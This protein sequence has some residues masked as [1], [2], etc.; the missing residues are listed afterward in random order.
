MGFLEVG[1]P[2]TWAENE[3]LREQIKRDGLTQ[4]LHIY[5]INRAREDTDL[6][7]GDEVEFTLV[8]LDH[9]SRKASICVDGPRVSI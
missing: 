3:L 6:K 2:L 1:A 4:L 7:W 9:E 5:N 8:H